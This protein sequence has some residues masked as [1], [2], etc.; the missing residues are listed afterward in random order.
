[1]DIH[2][3]LSPKESDVIKI[4]NGLVDFNLVQFPDLDEK[5]FA[6]FIRNSDGEIIGGVSGKILYA[7]LH[8][9]YLWISE[10]IRFKGFGRKILGIAETE[11]RNLGLSNIY[12]DTYSFQAPDFYRKLGFTEVGRYVDYPK[13]GIAKI[14]FQ[15][16]L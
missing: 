4:Y 9:N 6:V 11:A 15:K 5:K 16:Q 1:M 13:A 10:A 8:I 3:T 7:S 2:F 12:V 14:F